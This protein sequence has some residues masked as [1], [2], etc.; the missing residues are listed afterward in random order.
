MPPD[1]VGRERQT[2]EQSLTKLGVDFV[3]LWLVHWPPNRQATPAAWEQF[4]QARSDGLARSIGVSNY[5]LGQI[6]ELSQATGVT[7][8]VN[9]IR[10]GTSIYDPSVASGLEQRG[11]VLEGYSPFKASNLD[12]PTLTRI[13]SD[14]DASAAQ[15]IVAWHVAHNFVVIPKSVRQERIVANA[16][17]AKIELNADEVAA[18]DDLSG[19]RRTS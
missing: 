10:W 6:D 5:S 14:Y 7:P 3:D 8:E 12:D 19:G 18:L 17:G 1:N 2:L 16:A 4:V 11:V 13:A 9:Q 15:I